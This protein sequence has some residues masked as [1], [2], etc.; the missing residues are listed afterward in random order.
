MKAPLIGIT[1]NRYNTRTDDTT[2]SLSIA[3]TTA[4][5]NAGGL[6]VML[7]NEFPL[8][9]LDDLIAR[10]DGLIISGGGDIQTSRFNGVDN[11]AVDDVVVDRDELEI[12]LVQ[13]AIQADLP[14]LGICRGIQVMNVA[15]GGSLYTHIPDQFPTDLKH[16]NP[17]PAF[18]RS[19]IAHTVTLESGSLLSS[20]LGNSRV[21]V[22]SRHHQA[23]K[24]PAVGIFITA[25]ATDGLIE[26]IEIPGKRFAI[27]VQWH[28]ENLQEHAEHRSLFS[29]FIQ[30]AQ[31]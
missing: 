20:I 10:F 9:K 19:H 5:R 29:A 3:Y 24:D 26:G 4:V 1:T 12:R 30:A 7:P 13:K 27:G 16:S 11:S 31:V 2:N 28:P 18:P 23:V 8:D 21:N 22:N 14:L 6:P 17:P 15:L 25:H